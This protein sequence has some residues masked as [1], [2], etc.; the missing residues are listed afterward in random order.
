MIPYKDLSREEQEKIDKTAKERAREQNCRIR[1]RQRY[2]NADLLE[3][4]ELDCAISQ[5][6]KKC[7]Q[8][9]ADFRYKMWKN[10]LK[11]AGMDSTIAKWNLMFDDFG[12]CKCGNGFGCGGTMPPKPR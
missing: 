12:S 10:N 6:G 11:A 9:K 3:G 7:L 4:K 5:V 2:S 8:E 1:W